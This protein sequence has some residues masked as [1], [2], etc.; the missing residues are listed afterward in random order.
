MKIR[1]LVGVLMT[2]ARFCA[3][4]VLVAVEEKTDVVG[5][6][7]LENVVSEKIAVPSTARKIMKNAQF[8]M[9]HRAENFRGLSRRACR[10]KRAGGL[11]WFTHEKA[12]RKNKE[13]IVRPIW[14]TLQ[15]DNYHALLTSSRALQQAQHRALEHALQPLFPTPASPL[16][17]SEN[18]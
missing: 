15:D 11:F 12:Y 8:A 13:M 10:N 14:K 7:I 18:S 4:M 5:L 1:Q 17:L 9:L 16:S 6:M 2:N 3:K